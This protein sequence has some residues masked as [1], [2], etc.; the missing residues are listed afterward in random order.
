LHQGVLEN[1]M[2]LWD[3]DDQRAKQA[4]WQLQLFQ[5]LLPG[6]SGF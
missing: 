6:P 5:Q 1:L 4:L 3:I 2:D